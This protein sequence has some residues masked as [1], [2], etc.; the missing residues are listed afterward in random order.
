MRL[1]RTRL[2]IGIGAV[3]ATTALTVALVSNARADP[4]QEPAGDAAGDATGISAPRSPTTAGTASSKA[5]A[6]APDFLAADELPPHP[7]SGWYAG[8]AAAGTPEALFCIDGVS[9]AQGDVWHRDYWTEVDAGAQQIVVEARTKAAAKK[10]TAE[11]EA[12]TADCAARWLRDAP[13]SVAG[14]DDHGPLDGGDAAHLYAVH[15]A[16]PEAGTGIHGFGIGR[17]G[18]TV[19]VVQWGQMGSLTDLPV[20]DLTDTM[21]QA[22]EHLAG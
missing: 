10:L 12:A 5:P 11:L 6:T 13:G 4:D 19:T 17:V 16:P 20:A 2:A 3:M 15:T 9:L 14:W 7:S 8:D 22:L 21:G 18:T 1:T